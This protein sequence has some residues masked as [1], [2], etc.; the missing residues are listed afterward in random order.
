MFKQQETILHCKYITFLNDVDMHM[1]EICFNI[2]FI[3]KV[4]EMCQD[5]PLSFAGKS[6]SGQMPSVLQLR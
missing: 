3:L 2:F 4:K 5:N 1:Y 6:P